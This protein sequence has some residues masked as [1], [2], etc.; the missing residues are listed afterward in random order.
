MQ[1]VVDAGLALMTYFLAKELLSQVKFL[2]IQTQILK[3]YR[4]PTSLATRK[5]SKSP[6]CCEW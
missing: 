5:S 3:P 1:G 2:Q 6:R 4:I